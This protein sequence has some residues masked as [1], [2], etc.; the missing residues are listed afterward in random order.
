[1]TL[2]VRTCH[3]CYIRKVWLVSYNIYN[4]VK[5]LENP[6]L[7]YPWY[8]PMKKERELRDK[9]IQEED[10]KFSNPFSSFF[11]LTSK[12]GNHLTPLKKS[13][14]RK[15]TLEKIGTS[16]LPHVVVVCDRQE[17]GS[18]DSNSIYLQNRLSPTSSR[19]ACPCSRQQG[20][21]YLLRDIAIFNFQWIQFLS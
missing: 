18:F 4:G 15:K 20:L 9:T 2:E 17:S 1:M 12:N 8:L 13:V 5:Y 6:P 14:W 19:P 10:E 3:H 11:F 7:H 16:L 21:L